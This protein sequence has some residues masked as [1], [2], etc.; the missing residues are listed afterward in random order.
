[1]LKQMSAHS[2]TR[3]AKIYELAAFVVGDQPVTMQQLAGS[4]RVDLRFG[5][6]SQ[7]ELYILSQAN[8]KI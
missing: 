4:T 6:D 7:E 8:G 2:G 3:P 1:M 5:V